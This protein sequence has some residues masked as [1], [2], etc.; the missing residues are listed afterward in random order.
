M[1]KIKCLLNRQPRIQNEDEYFLSAVLLPL[2][3]KEGEPHILFEVRANHLQRQPGEICFP[4]G[5]IEKNEVE[6]PEVAAVREATEELGME[7][8]KIELLGQLDYLVTPPGT[9]IYPYV[10]RI[11]K[12]E[13]IC[14]NPDEVAEVF[15]VP[16]AYFLEN[17]PSVSYVDVATRYAADFPFH[18]VSSAY[19]PY[20][21]NRWTF[22]V[23]YY[24]YGKWFIWGMTA[25]IL[26]NFIKL[27]LSENAL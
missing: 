3:E 17:Q 21:Q 27:C 18:K 5:R 22:A 1:E 15:T 16:V 13:D 2:V 9:L 8:E 14:P 19:G 10:G 23:Y 24:E 4:G 12:P 6:T 7:K 20:W 25:R 11:L 26:Q